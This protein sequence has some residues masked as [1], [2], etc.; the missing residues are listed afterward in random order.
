MIRSSEIH[1]HVIVRK[2]D[3]LQS[4]YYIY[5]IRSSKIHCSEMGGTMQRVRLDLQIYM[6]Y[7]M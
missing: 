3:I 5:M 7:R 4:Y 2:H 6:I 1:K